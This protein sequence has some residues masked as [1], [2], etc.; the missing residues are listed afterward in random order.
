MIYGTGDWATMDAFALP[1]EPKF[2]CA[3]KQAGI[4]A[5]AYE[6]GRIETWDLAAKTLLR[7]FEGHNAALTAFRFDVSGE[8]LISGHAD[9]TIRVW[10]AEHAST[11]RVIVGHV[12][13]VY[14]LSADPFG[15]TFASAGEDR[16][17]RVWNAR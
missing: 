13:P 15:A 7:R 17:I 16:L 8:R 4:I 5:I 14:A 3:G 9:G 1:D 10:D 12:G 6:D 11:E 2:V